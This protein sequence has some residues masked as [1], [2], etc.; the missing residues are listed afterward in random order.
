MTNSPNPQARIK[1]HKGSNPICPVTYNTQVPTY[2]LS[3]H[4][5][6]KITKLIKLPYMFVASNSMK[7]AND[8]TQ[9]KIKNHKTHHIW[10]QRPTCKHIN[11]TYYLSWR[12]DPVSITLDINIKI[13]FVIL[14]TEILNQ[15]CS[16]FDKQYYKPHQGIAMGSPIS[17]LAHKI[18]LQHFEDIIMKH[19]I[20]RGEI[21]YLN[22]YKLKTYL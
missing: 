1:I 6:K 8:L 4:L 13:Q 10:H 18:Y 20:E 17:G 9:T 11:Q 5:T 16:Q 21:I 7:V 22:R 3:R 2:K 19:W 14:L 12:T 15:N